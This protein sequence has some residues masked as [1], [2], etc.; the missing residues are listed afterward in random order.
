MYDFS[1]KL[2]KVYIE[3]KAVKMFTK[4]KIVIVKSSVE[5][6]YVTDKKSGNQGA[7]R[8]TPSTKLC[9]TRRRCIKK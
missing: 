3:I 4:E 2:E 8:F 5:K 1:E 7:S 6:I 9:I